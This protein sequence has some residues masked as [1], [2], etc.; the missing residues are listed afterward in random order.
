MAA[1]RDSIIR[2]SGEAWNV[3]TGCTKVSAGCVRCYAERDALKMQREGSPW[4]RNGFQLTLHPARMEQ[5]L[6]WTRAR[7]IF[8][9]S[10]S[11]LSR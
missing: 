11:D 6:R 2:W 3:A 5:P 9:C 4:Y 7:R 1:K 8:V 10:M